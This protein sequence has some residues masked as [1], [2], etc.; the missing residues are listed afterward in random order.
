MFLASEAGVFER[1]ENPGGNQYRMSKNKIAVIGGGA[2]GMMAAI[3]AAASGGLVTLF[4]RNERLGK[5]ILATGNGRCNLGNL[6]IS[7]ADY[8]QEAREL[9][10]HCLKQFGT[11]DTIQFFQEAGLLIKN[12][13]GY[14]YPFSEQASAV[15][16]VLRLKVSSLGIEVLTESKVSHIFAQPNAMLE[17]G[18]GEQRRSFEKVIIACGGKAAPKTGSDGSGFK[19]AKQLGIQVTPLVPALVQLKCQETYCKA[20][21]GVRTDAL[22]KIWDREE[23]IACEK[24]ELLLTDYGISGIPVFQLSRIVN[25]RL[26]DGKELKAVIDFL[27]DCSQEEFEDQIRKRRQL[28]Q[29][30]TIE[31]FCT[32]MVHKKITLLCIKLAGL[33]TNQPIEEIPEE[34]FHEVFRLF[35]AFPLHVIG[36]N[37]YDNAQVSAGGVSLKEIS[38][39]LESLKVQG[40]YFAGEVLDVDGRCG[41]YNLQWA[42]TSGYVAGKAAA[43]RNRSEEL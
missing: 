13:N 32:G 2:A 6:Q 38:N 41:G 25:Y 39:N 37:S 5:K 35:K 16:D 27:P 29:N 20:L 8:N 11:E 26:R 12:R 9:V 24:G 33:K 10:K 23:E 4:E 14:L 1:V 22:V 34:L 42:W 40:V 19:L 3:S 7:E 30:R 18:Y 36:S 28:L 43:Q 17:I 31:E 21:A 15:L